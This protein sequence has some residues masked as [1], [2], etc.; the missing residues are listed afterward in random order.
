MAV[1]EVRPK[2]ASE[3]A[4]SVALTQLRAAGRE[5]G[6][7]DD[8]IEYLSRPQ[9]VLSVN[10]PV[11]M[12]DGRLRMFAGYR[13][14]HNFARGPAKG[15][16]RFHPSVTMDEVI[17]LAMWMTWKCAV[18]DIPYG[19]AKGGVVV[20]TK[21]LSLSELERLT[22]RFA[23]EISLLIGP[24]KDI[25][26]P[27]MY[28]NP[29]IMAWIMDTYSM[30][31]GYSIP[32]VVTGKPLEIGGS[33][34][35]SAATGRGAVDVLDEYARTKGIRLQGAAAVVQGF[36]N[37]G[38]AAARFLHDLGLK[39]I[40][41]GDITGAL[42]HEQ[43]L[44]IPAMLEHR[45]RYGSIEGYEGGEPISN[46]ELL[47][48]PCDVLVPAALENQL[49]GANADDVK[50][51][52]ILEG[53][54]GPTTPEADE[55]F[56]DKGIVVLPDILANA[57]GVTVSYFEWVQGLERFLWDEEEVN[58]RLRQKMTRALH[59][60]MEV[61]EREDVTYRQAAYYLALGRVADAV[62]IRG[63]YP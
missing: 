44:D 6:L 38:G 10:F 30:H 14:Q 63:I 3:D 26:A 55:I 57:G 40:G 25:P 12:D 17:A 39:V 53:A 34:G 35:R 2:P 47:A 16:I 37:V 13:V 23:T 59:E 54:N 42:Y 50:A 20:D 27:D 15:G 49:T 8:L 60:V 18:V 24:E 51:K 41:V 11:K 32:A 4:L 31:Q 36:G 22:R 28:T 58:R 62:R 46:E 56:R 48:L 21:A 33:L 43:G 52:I 5:L 19:G 61:A 1:T 45:D 29:Q 9:R 7:A